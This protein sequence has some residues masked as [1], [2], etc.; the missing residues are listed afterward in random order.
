MAAA[1]RCITFGIKLGRLAARFYCRFF[2]R[3]VLHMIWSAIQERGKLSMRVR[4][5]SSRPLLLFALGA[6]GTAAYSV[7]AISPAESPLRGDEEIGVLTRKSETTIRHSNGDVTVECKGTNDTKALTDA[8]N[9]ANGGWIVIVRGQTCAGADITIPKLRIEE[10]GLLKP[11]TSH[12]IALSGNFSAGPYQTF[13]NALSGQGTVTFSGNK[14]QTEIVPQ[15]WGATGNGISDDTAALNQA[16]AQTGQIVFVPKGSYKTIAPLASPVC[17]AI[18]GAGRDSTIFLPSASVKTF[19]TVYTGVLTLRGFVVDG[20]ATSDATGL[21]F[22][23]DTHYTAWGGQVD[24]VRVKNFKGRSGVGVRIADALKSSFTHITVEGCGID[25]L[26]QRIAGG[27]PDAI[28]FRNCQFN[29][30]ATKGA[31]LVDGHSITFD[32]CVFE[33]NTEEGVIL[34]PDPGGT[35]ENIAFVNGCWFEDNYRGNP[36]GYQFVAGDGT[37]Q[38]QATIRPVLR[39]T[40]FAGNNGTAKAINLTGGAVAGFIIDNAQVPNAAEEIKI[41]NDAYGVLANFPGHLDASVVV[42]STSSFFH[43]YGRGQIRFPV[44]PSPSG[45]P[46]TLDDY[47]EGTFTPTLA[48]GGGSVTYSQQT[49]SYTKIGRLVTVQILITINVATRPS[50]FLEVRS[51]PF[52]ASAGQKGAVSIQGD[53]LVKIA[54]TCLVGTVSAGGSVIRV[55]KFADGSLGNLGADLQNGTTLSITATYETN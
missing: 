3:I 6:I 19:M 50:G 15:L 10:G 45:D 39:D 28:T 4:L 35:L 37:G 26:V 44:T 42:S 2:T 43:L 18:N 38:R 52:A 20:A 31:K 1:S 29:T 41:Q 16:F 14:T 48:L 36:G 8:I 12:T 21:L 17:A 24:M 54:A 25:L 22:G 47:R 32:G 23:D 40:F 33:S 53:S 11:V 5:F 34:L 55:F 30:A 7:K 27:Y 13:T 9:A 49:G 46:N 51:L